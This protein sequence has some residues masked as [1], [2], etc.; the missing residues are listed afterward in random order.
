MMFLSLTV[1]VVAATPSCL[2]PNPGL[3][4]DLGKFDGDW[5][6]VDTSSRGEHDRFECQK[7]R[8]S[9]NIENSNI[10]VQPLDFE[11]GE[12]AG[13]EDGNYRKTEGNSV[14][15]WQDIDYPA[16]TL[17]YVFLG[18]DDGYQ[19]WAAGYACRHHHSGD[20]EKSLSMVFIFGRDRELSEEHKNEAKTQIKNA[21][22]KEGSLDE[23]KIDELTSKLNKTCTPPSATSTHP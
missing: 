16:F 8:I 10:T 19:H 23:M 9:H 15:I 7:Y 13:R 17:T 12:P 14:Y 20:I 22:L 18:A 21:L 1:T 4:L 2:T 11:K 6:I 5:Y 3:N